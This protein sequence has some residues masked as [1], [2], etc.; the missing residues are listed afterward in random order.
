MNIPS[1]F[2]TLPIRRA[3]AEWRSLRDAGMSETQEVEFAAWFDADE[4]HAIAFAEIDET[5]RTLARLSA[6]RPE[7]LPDPDLLKPAEVVPYPAP[8]S[9][10]R[11]RRASIGAAAA[12]VIALFALERWRPGS[13][14]LSA[15]A[16]NVAADHVRHLTLDDG[17][18]AQLNAGSRLEVMYS[19]QERRVRLLRGEGYFNVAKN[20][21]RPFV[22]E[23]RGIAV[24]ALGTAF[25]VRFDATEVEVLVT[26]GRVSVEEATR[27]TGARLIEPAQVGAGEK[28]VVPAVQSFAAPLRVVQVAAGDVE[29]SLDWHDRRLKF[30]DVTLAEAV[31]TFNRHNRHRLVISDLELSSRR[32]GGTFLPESYEAFVRLL[33]SDFNVVAERRETETILRPAR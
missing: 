5:Y 32:F 1:N 16:T 18:I 10:R 25:N 19:A 27:K 31:E 4:R 13:D 30:V 2:I 22:V 12:A 6:E 15:P 21:N 24:R 14:L 8:R 7:G 26:E 11:W 9:A 29:R 28:V 33:E 17:S 3:A 23:V 20:P